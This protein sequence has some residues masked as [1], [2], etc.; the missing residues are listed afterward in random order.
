MWLPL[1]LYS[2]VFRHLGLEDLV[3]LRRVN[4]LWKSEIDRIR[5]KQLIIKRAAT[6]SNK[7]HFTRD[8][9]N[10]SRLI[11]MDIFDSAYSTFRKHLTNLHLLDGLKRLKIA[12]VNGPAE[13][14]GSSFYSCLAKFRSLEELDIEFDLDEYQT[15]CH[16]N[17]KRLYIRMIDDAVVELEVD[18]PRLEALSLSGSFEPLDVIYPENLQHLSVSDSYGFDEIDL[19]SYESLEVLSCDYAFLSSCL[20]LD[21]LLQLKVFKLNSVDL[22]TEEYE[23]VKSWLVDLIERKERLGRSDLKVYFG[24]K[25]LASAG[26]FAEIDEDYLY[27]PNYYLFRLESA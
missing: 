5:F 14:F 16:P 2:F 21:H 24:E 4:K 1:E 25:I 19:K 9:I 18:C 8:P 13:V 7:W 15:I 23:F 3:R 17:L 22:E 27:Y 10:P 6:P 26:Q 11:E 12:S 20:N